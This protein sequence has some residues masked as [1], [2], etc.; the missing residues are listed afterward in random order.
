MTPSRGS[1]RRT[2]IQSCASRVVEGL[3]DQSRGTSRPREVAGGLLAPPRSR[4]VATAPASLA[5]RQFGGACA[6]ES[7]PL[8]LR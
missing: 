3:L 1:R 5:A 4:R 6:G 2:A 7:V 8:V